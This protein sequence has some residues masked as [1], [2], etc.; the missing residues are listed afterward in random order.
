MDVLV[1]GS[2]GFIGSALLPR[3][4]DAGHRPI[5]ALRAA[6]IPKGV[7]AI[8]WDPEAGTIDAASLE[9]IG[10]VVHLAGA[11]IGDKRWDDARK[12]LILES[13][14]TPTRLLAET[15]AALAKPPSV[16]V[17]GS[18]VGYYGNRGDEVLT[19]DSP[20]GG[21]FVSDVCVQWERAAQPAVDAGIRVVNIRTGIVL[22]AHGGALKQ[23]LL[24]FKLGIGGRTGSGKQ[25]MSWISLDDEVAAILHAIATDELRGPANLTAP[26]PA[27]N[28]EFT[29]TL[30][31][32]LHRPSLLPTP[33][34]PVKALYG[35]ELVQSLLLDGQR[36]LPKQ[37][38]GTGFSFA[39]PTLEVAL[40][41]VLDRPA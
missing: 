17:S 11:G 2:S 38:E 28:G 9:G 6:T 3:L 4:V 31:K 14:T 8:A 26:N 35:G 25:W 7:D 16:L 41:A 32:V 12:R 20:P 18:A 30:A 27:T 15:L 5:R 29:K 40:R 37:L 36:V 23:L 39:H 22:G 13:R 1:T 34:L 19:E 10:A 21:D 33:T 24:P